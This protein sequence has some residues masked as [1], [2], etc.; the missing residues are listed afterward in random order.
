M[1]CAPRRQAGVAAAAGAAAQAARGAAALA[2]YILI[3]IKHAKVEHTEQ[4]PCTADES[5]RCSSMPAVKMSRY[6]YMYCLAIRIL[7]GC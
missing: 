4:L 5:K 6:M 7:L 1:P 2:P 3:K